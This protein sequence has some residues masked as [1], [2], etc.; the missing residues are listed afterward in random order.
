V[1]IEKNE[2]V[3][4]KE[5]L[6]GFDF[7][8]PRWILFLERKWGRFSIP[9]AGMLLVLFQIIGFIIA[10]VHPEW[11]RRFTLDPD[12][13]LHGEFYRLFSFLF[14]PVMDN[15]LMLFVTWFFYYTLFLLR[16]EWGDF[17][18][19]LYF[20]ISWAGTI[21]GAFLFHEVI[22]SFILIEMTFFFAVGTLKP[23]YRFDFFFIL[24]IRMKWIALISMLL[25]LVQL[26][27]FSAWSMTLCLF[28]S[29]MNYFLFFIPGFYR[30]IRLRTH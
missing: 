19:S 25:L 20:V 28:L 15:F 27:F 18:L 5:T 26:L 21:A 14:I 30:S 9:Y 16:R 1:E 4:K 3:P 23:R 17:K 22:S 8:V 29:C 6:F 10:K 11:L 13:V 2:S 24:P 12:A 7:Q